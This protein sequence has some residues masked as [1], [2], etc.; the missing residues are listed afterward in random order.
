MKDENYPAISETRVEVPKLSRSFR[1]AVIRSYAHPDGRYLITTELVDCPPGSGR[2][3]YIETGLV[4]PDSERYDGHPFEWREAD[5]VT[6]LPPTVPEIEA[7]FRSYIN[8]G[9]TLHIGEI[10]DK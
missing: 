9:T 3:G 8:N 1:Q 10:E 2:R 7:F 4:V 6:N 5:P